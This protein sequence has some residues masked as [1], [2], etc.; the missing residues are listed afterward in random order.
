[1]QATPTAKEVKGATGKK[2]GEAIPYADLREQCK[3]EYEKQLSL[4]KSYSC[5]GLTKE[6][7]I[8]AARQ[9][10]KACRQQR[11]MVRT[12]FAQA[13]GRVKGA[14]QK[15]VSGDPL[16]PD[17]TSI[18]K[19]LEASQKNHDNAIDEV[20]NAFLKCEQKLKKFEK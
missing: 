7:E 10:A 9:R 20:N 8:E 12:I 19:E 5:D 14:L 1:M 17:L 2:G 6:N 4:C 13:I 16:K 11:I 15:M 18:L 3:R